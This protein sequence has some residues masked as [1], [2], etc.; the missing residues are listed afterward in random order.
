MCLLR[1]EAGDQRLG[2]G[3]DMGEGRTVELVGGVHH[4]FFECGG[5]IADQRDVVA[6]FRCIAGGGF[7]AGIGQQTDDDDVGDAFLLQAKIGS[8][9]AKPLEP[10]CS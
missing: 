10:Q 6:E 2:V 1:L 8:V 7:D 5:R 3:N 4:L 9:L